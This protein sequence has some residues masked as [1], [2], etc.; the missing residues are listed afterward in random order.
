[1]LDFT[2]HHDWLAINADTVR[3]SQGLGSSRL[4]KAIG[5]P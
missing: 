2:E 1:M 4:R 5:T 3:K